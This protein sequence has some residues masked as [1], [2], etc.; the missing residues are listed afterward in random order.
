M[1]EGY[2]FIG[3][4]RS[5]IWVLYNMLTNKVENYEDAD[6]N[7]YR[8]PFQE[9]VPNLAKVASDAETFQRLLH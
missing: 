4:A 6:F 9:Q 8:F 7:E 5:K 3:M 1:K 2:I